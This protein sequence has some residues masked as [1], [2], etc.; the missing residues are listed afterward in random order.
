MWKSAGKTRYKKI[1]VENDIL[2]AYDAYESL[3]PFENP[4]L[5][6]EFSKVQDSKSAV[7]FELRYAPL[8]YDFLLDDPKKRRGGD[9]IEWVLEQARFIRGA[10]ELVHA[11]A[12]EDGNAALRFY[13]NYVKNSNDTHPALRGTGKITYP[14]GAY[15]VP[16]IVNAPVTAKDALWCAPSIITILVN[17]N[18]THLHR[19]LMLD[20]KGKIVE[21]QLYRAL[22]EAMWS[23]IGTL[24][25]K[26]QLGEERPHFRMCKFCGTIFFANHGRQWFCPPIWGQQSSCGNAIRQ[27]KYQVR[28]K[29]KYK[30]LRQ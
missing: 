25:I 16:T 28:H 4:N 2:R 30:Y 13:R 5:P 17:G 22:T 27:R 10:L 29:G 11:I 24:A 26:A 18:T 20:S 8:D 14:S 12:N 21:V 3:W 15:C 6:S 9:P 23:M 1:C 19:E 7:K